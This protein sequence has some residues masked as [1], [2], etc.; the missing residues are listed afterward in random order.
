VREVTPRVILLAT[1]GTLSTTTSRDGHTAATL[2]ALQLAASLGSIDV[3]V[4]ARDL[5]RTPSWALD[6]SQVSEIARAA[7]DAAQEPGVDGVVLTHGTSTLEYTAF[8]ID[9]IVTGPTPV[10]LTGAMRR[11]DSESPDGPQN[12]RD[13]ITVATA[14]QA[15]GRGALVVFAGRVIAGDRAWKADR[16]AA[17]A[18]VDLAADLGA[19][20]DGMVTVRDRSP[21][22]RRF[23]GRLEPRVALVKVV[24]GMTGRFLEMALDSDLR[25][26]VIEALPG[27]GGVAP[28]MLP[29]LRDVADRL[30]VV[31]T[32]RAPFGRLPEAPTGGTGE[33]L[34]ELGLLS[35]IGLTAE[36]SWVLLMASLADETDDE[37]VRRR[38]SEV[39]HSVPFGSLAMEGVRR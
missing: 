13:A 27:A 17:D 32:S 28:G 23:S 12:L 9:L 35:A 2:T 31:L 24:P 1:G 7:R 30:P 22:P 11:A 21:R 3:E 5:E 33:P 15:R 8:L 20:R 37:D 4:V 18:F 36:Q 14:R 25:G 10:V 29:A 16:E 39:A 34:R 19:V 38:F 26:L 6:T